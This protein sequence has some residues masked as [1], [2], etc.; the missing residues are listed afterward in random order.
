MITFNSPN[1]MG[2]RCHKI[3]R[4][5]IIIKFPIP[6]FGYGFGLNVKDDNYNKF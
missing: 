3:Y 6:Y 1:L 2:G 4:K 5:Q